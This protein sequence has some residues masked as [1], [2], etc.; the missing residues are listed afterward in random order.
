MN[1]AIDSTLFVCDIPAGT[2][3]AGDVLNFK[4]N[5]GPANVR[6]GRGDA[7][8]KQI[9]TFYAASL[10]ACKW[11]IHV[12][13][14]D[15]ID[16]VESFPAVLLG[17]TSMDDHNGSIQFGCDDKLTQNSGWMVYAECISGGT[18]TTANSLFVL[19]D[20]DYPQVSAIRDPDTLIGVPTSIK[21]DKTTEA[22]QAIGALE[23]GT[24]SVVSV[25]YFK[26]GYAYCIQ[27]VEAVTTSNIGGGF[28]A[29]SNAAGMGGLQ[30]IIPMNVDINAIKYKLRYASKLVKGPMDVKLMLCAASATTTDIFMIHDYVKK[31]GA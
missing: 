30:R 14:S 13:N 12:K 5:L 17:A 20:I 21:F 16:D 10:G 3:A 8:L 7:I 28:L 25:D 22:V 23:N 29:F 1:V 15:W 26:A 6:S 24:W 31:A 4:V 18:T 2:Y 9:A 19:I 11:R 27:A